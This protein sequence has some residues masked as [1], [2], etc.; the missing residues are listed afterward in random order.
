MGILSHRTGSNA[1]CGAEQ[2]AESNT[3]SS[4]Y[5]TGPPHFSS[6]GMRGFQHNLFG[7]VFLVQGFSA[8]IHSSRYKV[9]LPMVGNSLAL[10][11]AEI[12]NNR[13]HSSDTLNWRSPYMFSKYVRKMALKRTL[14]SLRNT[15][16]TEQKK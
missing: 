15:A 6:S 9:A 10:S 1:P 14:W 7:V 12:W 4:T 5:A 3:D 2:S 13:Q 11:R 8:V 16:K